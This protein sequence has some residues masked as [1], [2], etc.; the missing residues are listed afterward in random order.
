MCINKNEH[1]TKTQN[2]EQQNAVTLDIRQ[3]TYRSNSKQDTIVPKEEFL[4]NNISIK[5]E[6]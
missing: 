4:E 5:Q 2:A 3:Q 1:I 6:Q